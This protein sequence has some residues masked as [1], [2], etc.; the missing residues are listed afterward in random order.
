MPSQTLATRLV[1]GIFFV[2]LAYATLRYV[3]FADYETHRLFLQVL[4]KA[5]S[6]TAVFSLCLAYAVSPLAHLQ[7]RKF[8]RW[9]PLRTTLGL[10]G[11]GLAAWHVLA[12]LVLMNPHYFPK[13]FEAGGMFNATGESSLMLGCLAFV[14]LLVPAASSLPGIEVRIGHRQ[15]ERFQKFGLWSTYLAGLHVAV[16]GFPGW[17]TPAGWPGGLPPITLLATLP[18]AGLALLRLT[19]SRRSLR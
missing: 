7:P 12:S 8:S 3:V 6:L 10:W 2:A 4:N 13:L 18:V 19:L 9:A 15:W 1:A 5:V 11:L 16:M 17:F 14:C